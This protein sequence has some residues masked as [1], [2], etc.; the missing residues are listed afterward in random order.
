MGKMLTSVMIWLVAIAVP[1]QGIAAATMMHC[2]MGPHRAQATQS[3]VEALP[4][5]H[6]VAPVEHAA[7]GHVSHPDPD[8]AT[9]SETVQN[10]SSP[11]A[12]GTARPDKGA[13][14]VKAAKTASQKCS[15]CASC[16]AG[17]ALPST[18][19][20]LPTI[21]P[22]HEVTALSPREAASVVVDGPERPP[23]ILRA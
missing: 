7:H 15:V 2:G 21:G 4:D 6:L 22:A 13:G 3:K 1:A 17:L 16:G 14:D 23:R 12:S 9:A 18:A 20:I 11:D 19:V 10:T 8:A 5:A